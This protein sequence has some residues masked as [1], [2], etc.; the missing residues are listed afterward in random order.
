[1]AGSK[2]ST[3]RFNGITLAFALHASLIAVAFCASC[4][5]LEWTHVVLGMVLF[6]AVQAMQVTVWKAKAMLSSEKDDTWVEETATDK[7][8]AG[9]SPKAA[10]TKSPVSKRPLAPSPLASAT[11]ASSFTPKAAAEKTKQPSAKAIEKEMQP[12][13]VVA[14]MSMEEEEEAA[15]RA[16]IAAS[17]E[18]E[19]ADMAA[20]AAAAAA[21]QAA[22]EAA[23]DA[24]APAA[25]AATGEASPKAPEMKAKVKP[26]LPDNGEED[27]AD[28]SDEGSP[29]SPERSPCERYLLKLEKKA[30][31]VEKLKQ[32][33]ASG[34][35]LEPNQLAKLARGDEIYEWILKLR[36]QLST[37]EELKRVQLATAP[38]PHLEPPP[39][40]DSGCTLATEPPQPPP[41]PPPGMAPSL[42]D[43]LQLERLRAAGLLQPGAGCGASPKFAYAAPQWPGLDIDPLAAYALH[44]AQL[45]ME[46]RAQ[47]Q[48][49]Y[50]VA[51]EYATAC[52]SMGFYPW[53]AADLY[54]HPG[55]FMC[56]PPEF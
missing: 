30:R 15:L 45:E 13:V 5:Y 1:M 22:P 44:A 3:Q 16:A 37:I 29:G 10:G 24:A 49:H 20:R 39:G 28:A 38:T 12:E 7:V 14:A 6:L 4:T 21:A 8:P 52:A 23:V 11:K 27:A 55:A 42:D 33:S 34:E 36:V 56:V 25:I 47:A 35:T 43:L 40:F 26:S 48:A 31:E 51:W 17:I 32:R 50:A 2:T 19:K 46:A 9:L 18:Q 54:T 41:P 53:S